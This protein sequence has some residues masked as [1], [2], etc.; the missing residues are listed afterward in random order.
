MTTRVSYL[1]EKGLMLHDQQDV[2]LSVRL[3]GTGLCYLLGPGQAVE[4]GD[5]KGY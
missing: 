1:G 3:M 2:R 5:L 4:V